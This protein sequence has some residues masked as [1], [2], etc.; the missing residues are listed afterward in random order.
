[1]KSK[2]NA[3]GTSNKN[4]NRGINEFKKGYKH[5]INIT[6]DEKGNLLVDSQSILNR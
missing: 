3:L 5:R 1:M 2:I 6:E 4:K